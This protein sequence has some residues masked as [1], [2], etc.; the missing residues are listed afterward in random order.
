MFQRRANRKMVVAGSGSL[1]II[2]YN[3]YYHLVPE[4]PPNWG[5][6]LDFSDFCVLMVLDSRNRFPGCVI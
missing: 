4:N 3:K 6:L 5:D 2:I 1:L